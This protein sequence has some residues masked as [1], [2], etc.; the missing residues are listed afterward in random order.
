MRRH[1]AN[2]KDDVKH[3]WKLFWCRRRI[4]A[5]YMDRDVTEGEI[6]NCRH[7]MHWL[8]DEIKREEKVLE[9]LI[10]RP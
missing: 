6:H 10:N 1:I 9:S 4:N 8:L 3:W 7:R 2:I 5:L